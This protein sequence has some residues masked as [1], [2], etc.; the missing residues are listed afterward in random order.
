MRFTKKFG[1]S[2]VH[3]LSLIVSRLLNNR[4]LVSP[5]SITASTSN[6]L[7][8]FSTSFLSTTLAHSFSNRRLLPSIPPSLSASALREHRRGR[9]VRVEDLIFFCHFLLPPIQQRSD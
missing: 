2:F 9:L 1:V 8:A 3:L 7:A 4:S 5:T 6:K